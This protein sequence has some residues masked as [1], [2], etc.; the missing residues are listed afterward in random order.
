MKRL[1]ILLPLLLLLASCQQPYKTLRGETMG[2][3]YSVTY[4]HPSLEDLQREVDSLLFA[5]NQS[6]STYIDTATISRFNYAAECA[7]VDSYFI[8]VFKRAKVIHAATGGAFEPTVMPLVNAWGF[9]FENRQEMNPQKV[10][11]LLGLVGF[12][13]V[14]LQNG[15]VCKSQQGVMLDFSAIAKGY[16]VDVIANFLESEG[17][18]NYMVEIGGEVRTLGESAKEEAWQIG[19]R[20]PSDDPAESN[21]LRLILGLHNAALATSGN[22]ENF[23]M[24]DGQKYAHTID[25]ETGTPVEH[26]LLSASVL[27]PDC[28]TA[29]AWAT[30]LMVMGPQAAVGAAEAHP[31]LDVF[32]IYE[33]EG[34]LHTYASPGFQEV[35]QEEI[36]L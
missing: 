10:D 9:G 33:A 12:E 35:I 23:Y 22:Y 4:Q 18:I 11:S 7:P 25:P 6:L 2:T 19:I 17:I 13:Q 14:T 1:I 28:M 29:D 31:E 30:A 15:Q 24:K 34:E 20:K 26:G 27:A 21:H 5:L 16:A 8:A 36:T 32:L 3:T